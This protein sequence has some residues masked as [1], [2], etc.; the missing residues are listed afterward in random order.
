ML[1]LLGLCG[2]DLPELSNIQSLSLQVPSLFYV[3]QH[4]VISGKE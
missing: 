3:I 1:L 2:P 4:I